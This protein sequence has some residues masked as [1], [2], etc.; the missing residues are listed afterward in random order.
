[1]AVL[2]ADVVGEGEAVEVLVARAAR[3]AEVRDGGRVVGV[4][5]FA[6]PRR[7]AEGRDP[8]KGHG[9]LGSEASE[10]AEAVRARLAR[11]AHVDGSLRRALRAEP[12]ERA[13]KA[14]RAIGVRL[15]RSARG[16]E[17]VGTALPHVP[18]PA[19]HV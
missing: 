2:G 15:T 19:A 17:A 14:L 13:A 5:R 1:M 18:H 10:P 6:G 8:G 9:A 12:D 4:A 3:N 11:A 7:Q 16:A